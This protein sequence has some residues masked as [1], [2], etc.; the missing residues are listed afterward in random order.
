MSPGRLTKVHQPEGSDI[1]MRMGA[2]S[3]RV[4]KRA[5]DSR[6]AA[7][8]SMRGVMSW[9]M[10][11]LAKLRPVVGSVTCTEESASHTVRPSGVRTR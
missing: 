7:S 2:Q 10:P 3:A 4:R 5:S 1:H 8:A 11:R 9:R 6:S